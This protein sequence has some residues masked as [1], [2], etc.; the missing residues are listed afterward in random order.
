MLPT[1]Y[2]MGGLRRAANFGQPMVIYLHP[3]EI[4]PDQPRLP[5]AWKSRL[6]QYTGLEGMEVRLERLIS[7]Y[8]FGAIAEAFGGMDAYEFAGSNAAQELHA[9]HV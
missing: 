4:D 2:L 5:V 9:I 6:R 7:K 8:D 1:P 3:W